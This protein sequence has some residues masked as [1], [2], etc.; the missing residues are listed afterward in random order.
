MKTIAKSKEE[1]SGRAE[2][3][4]ARG[5]DGLECFQAVDL[6]ESYGKHS[7][8][9]YSLGLIDR[10]ICG[11]EHKGG[12]E[13]CPAGTAC[14]INAEQ[15]HSGN[16]TK[17]VP[18]S[19]R[20]IYIEPTLWQECLPP[21]TALPYFRQY[22]IFDSGSVAAINNLYHTLE[23]ENSLLARESCLVNTL[24][25]F[26]RMY[27][28]GPFSL[29]AGSEPA[30]VRLVREYLHAHYHDNISIEELTGLTFLNRAY[31]IRSFKKMVGLTPY[32]YLLQVRVEQA[33][34]LLVQGLTPA[35]AAVEVGFTD[36]SHLNRH[37]KA[38]TG[39]TP[40]RYSTGHYRTRI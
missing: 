24:S 26:T 30:A 31:L 5:F 10:G 9:A 13:S 12:I 18:L 22:A 6:V 29:L 16:V 32:A 11:S 3:W 17:T 28:K 39:L 35:Q 20:M 2:A 34:K 27:G 37:F 4:Q 1:L 21:G 40:G 38:I 33:K 8:A 36:Q 14:V 15:I 25:N 19:Y 23:S 7:H